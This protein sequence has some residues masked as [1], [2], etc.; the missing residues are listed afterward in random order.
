MIPITV[1]IVGGDRSSSRWRTFGFSVIYA[2][3]LAS[4]YSALG[5]LAGLTG[6]L[7]GA[8][9]TNPWLYFAMAN[10]MII[11]AAMMADVIPVRLPA[12]LQQ[13]VGTVGT[14]GRASGAFA[15]GTVSG[16]VAAPCGAPVMAGIL[17]WVT[18]S[19]S[20]GLGFLY[21][22]AFSFGMCALLL[23]VALGADT[24]L[25]LPRPG[26]WM[27]NVKRFFALVLLGV[28]EYYLISMG[29][30]IL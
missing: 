4:A 17:S 2:A 30:L 11:A 10:V 26:A 3:G 5:L 18:V 13:Y 23:A 21:L 25:R 8:V 9:S 28:A 20:A 29:Q 19:R 24:A 27:T 6:T 7:F 16:L 12:A 15:M 14:G 22:L 1:A